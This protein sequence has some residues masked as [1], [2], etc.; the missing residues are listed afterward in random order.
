MNQP[1]GT[2]GPR[3]HRA[4]VLRVMQDLLNADAVDLTISATSLTDRARIATEA[5][6]ALVQGNNTAFASA[7]HRYWTITCNQIVVNAS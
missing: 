5:E 2:S 6:K 3:S 1:T 7:V 4:D